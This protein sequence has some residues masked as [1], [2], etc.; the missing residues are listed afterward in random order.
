MANILLTILQ[1]VITVTG[2]MAPYLLFGFGIA[3]ILQ[4]IL[5]DTWLQKHLGGSGL[6]PVI[7]AVLL[8][9]PLPLCSCGV[10]GVSA[11]LR[12]QGAS[13]AAITGFLIATPQTGV[14]SILATWGLLGPVLGVFRPLIAFVT[15]I[16]GGAA[17]ALVERKEECC[18]SARSND[19]TD[20]E[21]CPVDGKVK[22]GL[23]E[24]LRYGF[25]TLPR[26]IAKPLV[27]GIVLSGLMGA[28][29][30]QDVL[31]PYIGGG[32]LAMVVMVAIGIPLYVCATASIPLAVGFIHLGA[33]PGAALA[34]LIAGPATNAATIATV[35]NLLGRK[36]SAIY[37]GTVAVGGILSGLFFDMLARHLPAD[38]HGLSRMHMHEGEGAGWFSVMAAFFLVAVLVNSLYGHKW[39]TCWFR[40]A[41]PYPSLEGDKQRIELSVSGMHCENCARALTRELKSLAG[42]ETVAINAEK[43]TAQV[44]GTLKDPEPILEA[45][46]KLGYKPCLLEKEIRPV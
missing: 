26:D 22:R 24:V 11:S 17:V 4:V 36:A 32:M 29:L 10:I 46:R 12:R 35:W 42:V 33:S 9:V 38:L 15:G 31:A 5:P 6:K 18:T 20:Q 7:K 16:A 21:C 34:F 43:G 2:H 25:V 40:K 23:L 30:P 44:V 3:G 45:I 27:V 41:G 28:L 14:D 13:R 39:R 37:V 1:E 8:G 19:G